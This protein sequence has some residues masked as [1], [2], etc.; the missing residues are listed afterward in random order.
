MRERT[1]IAKRLPLIMAAHREGRISKDSFWLLGVLVSLVDRNGQ[2]PISLELLVEPY[3]DGVSRKTI[4]RALKELI[5]GNY[6]RIS[7]TAGGY[8]KYS[9][10]LNRIGVHIYDG[11]EV[12]TCL[13]PND[14]LR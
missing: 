5:N 4:K 2:I 8:Y 9:F 12:V 7:R 11:A 10:L 13:C 1:L 6:L 3:I 14:P